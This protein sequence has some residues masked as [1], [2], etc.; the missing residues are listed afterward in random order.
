MCFIFSFYDLRLL[1]D[2][3]VLSMGD[4]LKQTWDIRW[5]VQ[6]EVP[7]TFD[8]SFARFGKVRLAEIN[9]ATAQTVGQILTTITSIPF[10]DL[11]MN[12]STNSVNTQL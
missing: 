7:A 9:N 3:L 4:F 11:N 6:K 2:R 12:L 10:G 5:L 1:G 8:R